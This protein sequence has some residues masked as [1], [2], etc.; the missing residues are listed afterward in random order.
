MHFEIQALSI[1][2]GRRTTVGHCFKRI[3]AKFDSQFVFA[4]ANV[5]CKKRYSH[6]SNTRYINFCYGSI[7][8]VVC[9]ESTGMEI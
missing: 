8:I 7:A 2:G 9:C 1:Y 4:T 5:D 6:C 3:F